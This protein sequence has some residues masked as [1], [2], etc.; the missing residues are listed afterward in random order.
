LLRR[1]SDIRFGLQEK[2]NNFRKT[3]GPP[4]HLEIIGEIR[5]LAQAG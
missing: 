3:T 1:L 4:N 5:F 2:Q